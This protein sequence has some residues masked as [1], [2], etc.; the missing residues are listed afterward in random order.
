M[1]FCKTATEESLFISPRKS[2][3]PQITSSDQSGLLV[4]S[5]LVT[6]LKKYNFPQVLCLFSVFVDDSGAVTSSLGTTCQAHTHN[7]SNLGVMKSCI[8]CC[9]YFRDAEA[10]PP[11]HLS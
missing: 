6:S 3:D 1:N 11:L 8:K 10:P 2:S 9:A 7:H 5:I 4:F